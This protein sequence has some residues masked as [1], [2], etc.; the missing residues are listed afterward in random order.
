MGCIRP[1]WST[2]ASYGDEKERFFDQAVVKGIKGSWQI[3]TTALVTAPS[4]YAPV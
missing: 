1:S 4:N 3:D 2:L